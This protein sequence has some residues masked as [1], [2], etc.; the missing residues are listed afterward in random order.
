MDKLAQ[1]SNM[2]TL[3]AGWTFKTKELDRELTI[4]PPAP[5]YTAHTVVDNLGNVYAGCGF[6]TACDYIP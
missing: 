6:D 4:A 1:L 3:P 5:S 2:L